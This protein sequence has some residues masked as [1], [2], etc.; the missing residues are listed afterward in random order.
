MKN[1][2]FIVSI[3]VVFICCAVSTSC[4]AQTYAYKYSHSV[5]DGVKVPG[6]PS[7]GTV[8]YF[9]FINGKSM[10]YLTDSNGV[11]NGGYGMNTYR[12]IGTKNGMHIYQEQCTNVFR[13][14]ED[15]LYFSSDFS[16]LNWQN[17]DIDSFSQWPGCI[18]VLDYVSDPN[19]VEV[20][21]QLY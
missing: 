5:K 9:T 16:K 3:A 4:Y 15:M 20:P 14:G 13:R 10:C 1:L 11:Y 18:R 6:V 17:T 8:F 21:D 12:F 2:K 7:K 19:E